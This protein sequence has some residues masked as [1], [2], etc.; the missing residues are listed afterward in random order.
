MTSYTPDQAAAIGCLDR[1]LQ[2]IACAGSGKTQVISQRIARILAQ[3]GVEPRNVVAFTFTEKAAAELKDRVLSIVEAERGHV[4]GLAEMYIGTMHGYALD[5]VQRL[6]PETFKYSVLTDITARMLVDRNSKKSGLTG[7]PT[8]SPKTPHLRRYVNSAL[9]LQAMSVLRED[10][11]DIELVPAGVLDS[12]RSYQHLLREHA[13]FDYTQMINLAV[14]LLESDPDEGPTERLVLDHVREDIRYVVV[15]EYQDVNPLQERLVRGLIRFGANL[16]VVGDDDQT[17]YQWRGSAVANIITFAERYDGVEQVTLADNFRSSKGVVELGRSIA[18]SIPAGQRLDKTMVAAGHQRWQRGDLL[19]LTFETPADEAVWI[20]DRI[21]AMRGLAFQDG[22]DS[23]PRGLSWSDFA[24]LFRSVA[25][26]ADAL[27]EELRRRGVPYVVKG[28]NRLFDSPEIQ[29]VVGIFRYVVAELDA[30][31]LHELWTAAD[32]LPDPAGWPIAL[33]VLDDGRDFDKGARWSI[34]NIQRL[35]LDFLEALAIREDTVPGDSA[36]AELVFYQLGK[37]SQAISDFEQIY[38]S[39]APYDKYTT[40][41]KWLTHQAPGYYA[42]SDADVGYASPDAVV[43]STVHQAK[44]RQ[45]PAVFVPCLRKNRF[46][47]RRWGGLNLFHVIPGEAIPDRDRYRGT[48]E[49]ETRLF[50]V[51]LTRAQKHLL[52]TYSP[53]SGQFSGRSSF[54]DHCTRSSWVSTRDSGVDA[55]ASRLAPRPRHETPQVTLSFSELKYWFECPYTFKLRF[56][57]GFNPPLHEALGYGKGLHDALAEV[58]KRAISGDLVDEAVASELVDRHLHTPY[59]YPEL[60]E[61]LR[62]SAVDAVVR[63]LHEHRSE[64]PRTIH[65]EKQIQ[66]HVAPGVVVDGRIDLVRRLDTDELAIVDFKS[67][68]RA[69]AEEVTWDQLHVYAVGYEEL[70]GERADVVEVLNLDERAQSHRDEVSEPLL[71]GVRERIRLAGESLRGNDLPRHG[72]W[73]TACDRC[74]LSGLCRTKPLLTMEGA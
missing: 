28:L 21:Q 20:C 56:L 51:A 37:F 32:L 10:D 48:V 58:H 2:I 18:D 43:L 73:C 31:G 50:Y 52:L 23:E 6:V 4:A 16:C 22:P 34:Y 5:L 55:S 69:Q 26:D 74:D 62:R 30:A 12:Y 11:V 25:K 67:S 53:G 45:W 24:V 64:L 38:F 65:S 3:D 41:A 1:P 49:D 44:G 72:S 33:K 7:C 60:R 47:S 27:V 39:S 68:D 46:P 13:F 61:S 29:A 66:V 54:F 63:Y 36:R 8:S 70:T 59:A 15:D 17:I 42:D 71:A 9:Y 35:Y 14:A 19:A 57:Y 40:F